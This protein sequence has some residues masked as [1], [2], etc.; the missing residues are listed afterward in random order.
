MKA[1]NDRRRRFGEIVW[2]GENTDEVVKFC[3]DWEY[4]LCPIYS[5][6]DTKDGAKRLCIEPSDTMRHSCLYVD[7][8]KRVVRTLS[9]AWPYSK[10][11]ITEGVEHDG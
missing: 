4:E 3:C 6:Y 2:N 7:L 11:I 8:G 9:E 10:I 1:S 5:V